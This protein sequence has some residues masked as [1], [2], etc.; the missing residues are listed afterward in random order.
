MKWYWNRCF[1]IYLWHCCNAI[2]YKTEY[3]WSFEA[4]AFESSTW[5]GYLCSWYLVCLNVV[6]SLCVGHELYKNPANV[7]ISYFT[8]RSDNC[9][10]CFSAFFPFIHSFV[11]HK[12][13]K[14]C[15]QRHSIRIQMKGN[16]GP[17]MEPCD[18]RMRYY[19]SHYATSIEVVIVDKLPSTICMSG[20]QGHSISFRCFVCLCCH[21]IE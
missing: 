11:L 2:Q 21:K 13:P 4:E 12:V 18:N 17:T 3:Q 1:C 15:S 9:S 8:A 10:F 20:T 5:N 7:F 6:I 14:H 19:S 16:Y